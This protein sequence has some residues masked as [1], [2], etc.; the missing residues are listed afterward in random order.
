M[1]YS[2]V[3]V[4]VAVSS[5]LQVGRS[6]VCS[7]AH[8]VACTVAARVHN[9]LRSSTW[10]VVAAV[11]ASVVVVVGSSARAKREHKSSQFGGEDSRAKVPGDH[12]ETGPK[13]REREREGLAREGNRLRW[14]L[15]CGRAGS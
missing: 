9:P 4:F 10:T 13:G 1:H 12:L 7:L 6:A 15:E 5:C 11:V 8:T 3:V 2:G 14:S